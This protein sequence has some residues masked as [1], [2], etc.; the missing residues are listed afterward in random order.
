MA[1]DNHGSPTK[2]EATNNDQHSMPDAEQKA[3]A[4]D[5]GVDIVALN[6]SAGAGN[7]A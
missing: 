3:G 2:G 5:S 4:A 6:M 1:L 7:L